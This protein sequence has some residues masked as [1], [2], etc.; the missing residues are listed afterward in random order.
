MGFEQNKFVFINALQCG[1]YYTIYFFIIPFYYC[2]KFVC[3]IN[4]MFNRYC[5]NVT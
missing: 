2:P 4:L 1:F 5:C 3:I